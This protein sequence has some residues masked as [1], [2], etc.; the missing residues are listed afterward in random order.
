[1]VQTAASVDTATLRA[2]LTDHL[3]GS[4][5]GV[6]I[7]EKLEEQNPSN[8]FFKGLVKSIKEDKD[9]LERIMDKVGAQENPVKSAGAKVAQS[10]GTGLSGA[11]GAGNAGDMGSVREC[12][13]LMMGITGKLSLWTT[14]NEIAEADERLSAFKYDGLIQGAKDQLAGLEAERLKM[15][16]KAFLR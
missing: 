8:E 2:Y 7:A 9:T 10:I 5:M 11:S 6:G 16:R 14:L 15:S 13:G 12:E 4:V 1:M 3:A